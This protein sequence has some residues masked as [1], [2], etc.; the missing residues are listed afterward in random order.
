MGN[1]PETAT[2]LR[3]AAALVAAFLCWA[4]TSPG[5]QEPRPA[6][7]HLPLEETRVS[8]DFQ[9]RLELSHTY[10]L[11]RADQILADMGWGADQYARWIEAVSLVGHY[12]EREDPELEAAV[13]K[14][15]SLQKDDG[16]I[17]MSEGRRQEWWG[18]ARALVALT[19]YYGHVKKDPQVLEA[20]RRLADYFIAK[21]PI[22]ETTDT[23][24]HAHY[25]SGLE[26][27]VYLW[28]FTGDRKYLAFAERVAAIIDPTVA[29]PGPKKLAHQPI[30]SLVRGWEVHQHHT[31]S[32]LETVQGILDLYRE[33]GQERFLKQAESAWKQTVQHTMWVSG[34]IPEVFGE[35]FEHNDE[36]CPVSSWILLNLKLLRETG[37]SRYADVVEHSLLNHLFFNQ[38]HKGG[39]YADRSI[40]QTI[41]VQPDNRGGIADACCSM[42]GLRGM[43]EVIPYVYTVSSTG[44]DVNFFVPSVTRVDLPSPKAVVRLRQET[45]FPDS[46]KIRLQV[47]PEEPGLRFQL[48]IRAPLWANAP[49]VRVNETRFSCSTANGYLILDRTWNSGDVVDVTLPFSLALVRSGENGF[50]AP[51]LTRIDPKVDKSFDDAAL[52]Y[53]P[54]TLMLD[55]ERSSPFAGKDLQLVLA[56]D[57]GGSLIP[58]RRPPESAASGRDTDARSQS[59]FELPHAHLETFVEK[60]NGPGSRQGVLLVPMSELT[61]HP[62]LRE[63]PYRIRFQVSFRPEKQDSVRGE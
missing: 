54:L 22:P 48:R 15:L 24:I 14:F 33:T 13:R 32:Y 63:D 2:S 35:Y 31:H 12:L 38:D 25:H 36:T 34:G 52:L 10:L 50:N 45:E 60:A 55:A 27:M 19:N 28:Q 49:S 43:F 30:T 44:I 18:A 61:M 40:C 6:K 20:A 26:G 56:C 4:C 5:E 8:G 9:S 46:D 39:F 58:S 37:D 42:H 51:R 3:K 17:L 7:G 29:V 11:G 57:Q 62:T 41:R 47:D 23:L 59:Q 53:G 16:S 21:A 1:L